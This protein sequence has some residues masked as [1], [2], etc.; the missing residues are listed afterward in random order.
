MAPVLDKKIAQ[1]L[2]DIA[3]NLRIHSIEA[4]VASNSGF[5]LN[6]CFFFLKRK[7]FL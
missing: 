4:T 3:H 5:V 6:K 7:V 2:K 1:I